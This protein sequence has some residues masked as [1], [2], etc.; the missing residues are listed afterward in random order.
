MC[1]CINI[2]KIEN[3]VILFNTYF[4]N[5]KIHTDSYIGMSSNVESEIAEAAIDKAGKCLIAAFAIYEFEENMIEM[6]DEAKSNL[7]THHHSQWEEWVKRKLVELDADYW[8]K[9][10]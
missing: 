10:F 9:I 8:K 6:T 5:I 2:Y 3:I 7:R 1:I 4:L